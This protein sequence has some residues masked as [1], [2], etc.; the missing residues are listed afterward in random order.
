M[1]ETVFFTVFESFEQCRYVSPTEEII[2]VSVWKVDGR[3]VSKSHYLRCYARALFNAEVAAE[4]PEDVTL[5]M[6]LLVEEW[7][8]ANTEREASRSKQ[9]RGL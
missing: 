5:M 8:K 2:K 3:L 7:R 6:Y 1:I 9:C 4:Q